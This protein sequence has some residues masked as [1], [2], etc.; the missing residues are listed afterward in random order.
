MRHYFK[1]T[2]AINFLFL[3]FPHAVWIRKHSPHTQEA[4]VFRI[5][6]VWMMHQTGVIS[7]TTWFCY[8]RLRT[9][10]DDLNI[11]PLYTAVVVISWVIWRGDGHLD[12]HFRITSLVILKGCQSFDLGDRITITCLWWFPITLH[13]AGSPM[14]AF[15]CPGPALLLPAWSFQVAASFLCCCAPGTPSTPFQLSNIKGC[16]LFS[17]FRWLWQ[18]LTGP[19]WFI[20][21]KGPCRHLAVWP[22]ALVFPR[23]T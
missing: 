9:D 1:N 2:A 10:F 14:A 15:P 8:H 21:A 18:P 5:K 20:P 19:Y 13:S 17:F 7:S 16:L 3:F 23:G 12:P 4:N 22:S 6:V 11:G